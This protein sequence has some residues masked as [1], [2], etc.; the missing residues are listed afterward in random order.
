M[1]TDAAWSPLPIRR[2]A[3]AS[4]NAAQAASEAPPGDTVVVVRSTSRWADWSR[5]PPPRCR[6]AFGPPGR[7]GAADRAAGR[8]SVVVVTGAGGR[9]A[10]GAARSAPHAPS[11]VTAVRAAAIHRAVR[12]IAP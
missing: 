3:S 4:S 11:A 7:S 1:A 9:V 12:S 8:R 6:R 2:P 10:I 5:S